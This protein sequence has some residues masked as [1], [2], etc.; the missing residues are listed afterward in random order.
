MPATATISPEGD[1]DWYA[2]NIRWPCV[3][4]FQIDGPPYNRYSGPNFLPVLQIFDQDS[5]LLA[6]RDDGSAGDVRIAAHLPAGRYYLRVANR[7]GS[8]SPGTYSVTVKTVRLHHVAMPSL[9]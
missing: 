6:T 5:N 9:P 4:S 3:L 7:G 2:A 8:R 1:V